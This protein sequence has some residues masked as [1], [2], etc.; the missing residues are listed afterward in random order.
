MVAEGT[1]RPPW[2]HRN[3]MSEYM[4]LITGQY[5]AK[6]GGFV[7][8]GAS[9]H[10]MMSAHGPDVPSHRAASEATLAPHKLEGT[11]AFMIETRFPF[12]VTP[13][14]AATAQRDYDACWTGFPPAQVQP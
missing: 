13:Q 12:A 1:F 6:A 4:G 9:L 8:G 14:A 10:N 11:M 3:V 2:F 7:P 5:D